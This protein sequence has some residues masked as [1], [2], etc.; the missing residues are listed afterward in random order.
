M[1]AHKQTLLIITAL[2]DYVKL[3]S[4]LMPDRQIDSSILDD[5]AVARTHRSVLKKAQLGQ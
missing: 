3:R 4:A 5:S 2:I 1:F